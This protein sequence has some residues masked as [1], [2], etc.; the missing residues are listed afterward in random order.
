VLPRAATGEAC[1]KLR[2]EMNLPLGPGLKGYTFKAELELYGRNKALWAALRSR[3]CSTRP[4]TGLTLLLPRGWCAKASLLEWQQ[5][6]QHSL[7]VPRPARLRW[8]G[9]DA[10]PRQ[11]GAILQMWLL[12]MAAT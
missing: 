12:S 9:A 2:K 4:A 6:S 5:I 8:A 7:P 10:L 3:Q 1:Q 11:A